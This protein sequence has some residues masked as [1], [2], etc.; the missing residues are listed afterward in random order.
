M[1]K[2]ACQAFCR[3]PSLCRNEG[4]YP[5]WPQ[6]YSPDWTARLFLSSSAVQEIVLHTD[7]D[8]K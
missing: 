1:V 3:L 7:P 5:K 6:S 4:E 8:T 2:E